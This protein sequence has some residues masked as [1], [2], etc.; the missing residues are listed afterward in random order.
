[1]DFLQN[2]NGFL[3]PVTKARD[4]HFMNLIYIL[5]YYC[6]LLKIPGYDADCPSIDKNMYSHLCCSDQVKQN[7]MI[8]DD[9]SLLPS[10]QPEHIVPSNK[11]QL[12]LKEYMSDGE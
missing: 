6:D 2:N 10:Q 9:F 4:G 1:M 3:P 8:L 7:S 12:G 11:I 5:Q